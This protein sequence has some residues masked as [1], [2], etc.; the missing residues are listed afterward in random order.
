[1]SREQRQPGQGQAG[2][3]LI[4]FLIAATLLA[5]M[6]AAV[7]GSLR[8]ALN[9][10]TRSQELM[11]EDGR[12]RVLEDMVRRQL[13]SLY[14]LAPS[15][16]LS[17]GKANPMQ[18]QMPGLTQ[19]GLPAAQNPLQ[20]SA[21][22][23]YGS[24]SAL[25]FVTVAPF[26]TIRNPGLTVVRY[27]H[28]EDEW[29]DRYFGAMEARY[30]GSETFYEMVEV[31][32]GAPIP[33]IKNVTDLSFEY[34]GFNPQTG[35]GEWYAEWSSLDTLAVPGAVRISV[36]DLKIVVVINAQ[37]GPGAETGQQLRK[38]FSGERPS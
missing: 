26:E 23:F 34:Y 33:I 2:F 8:V 20:A 22:L 4:E 10:Y 1:M 31:P 18:V 9:S 37:G 15:L 11:Q 14:P 32:T 24:S 19:G 6:G 25:T 5:L 28:A 7:F 29:G 17:T 36:D 38:L 21:P 27:G 35:I 12:Q 16:R 3:T 13:G 30:R